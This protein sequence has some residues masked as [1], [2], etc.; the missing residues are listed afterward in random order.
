MKN[1]QLARYFIEQYVGPISLSSS[2]YETE[3]WGKL[4]QD[5][6]INV[7][8]AVS[9]SLEPMALLHRL[10][11]IEKKLGRVRIEK[12][13]ARTMDIDILFYDSVQ[14][15]N[16][17]LKIPHP[18]ITNRNFVLEPLNEILP[19]WKHPALDKSISQLLKECKDESAV[20]R[21]EP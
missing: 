12:W 4:D 10:Q 16:E 13:G 15:E 14:M 19:D 21:I 9:T 20:R 8:Y 18:E 3:P 5:D 2:L 7:V 11:W 17:E 6:F 1:I